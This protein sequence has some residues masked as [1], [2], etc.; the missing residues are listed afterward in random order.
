MIDAVIS[1]CQSVLNLLEQH[2]L[3]DLFLVCHYRHCCPNQNDTSRHFDNLTLIGSN[4]TNETQIKI[5]F[6][7]I[8]FPSFV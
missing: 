5:Q 7:R 1:L 6:N 8:Y 3:Y 4:G 2:S